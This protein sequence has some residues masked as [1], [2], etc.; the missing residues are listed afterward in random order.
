MSKDSFWD[1]ASMSLHTGVQQKPTHCQPPKPPLGR[2]TILLWA[3]GGWGRQPRR[4]H[5]GP[6]TNTLS[7][8]DKPNFVG[9][10]IINKHNGH[11]LGEEE[12]SKDKEEETG[13]GGNTSEVQWDTA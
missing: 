4:S 11:Y 1:Q 5:P 3:L 2:L 12:T 7:Q 9:I 8:T 6:L 10:P 13:N